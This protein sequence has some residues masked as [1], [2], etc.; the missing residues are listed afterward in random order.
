MANDDWINKTNEINPV[1]IKASGVKSINLRDDEVVSGILFDD[2]AAE[3][4]T[5]LTDKGTGKRTRMTELE[6]TSRAK[7]GV[8]LMKV[9]QSNPSRIVKA[10][11]TNSKNLIGIVSDNYSREVK[12]NEI[13][14]MDRY[15]TGSAIVKTKI[16][17]IY[18]PVTLIK[19]SEVKKEE[20]SKPVTKEESKEKKEVSLKEIDDKFMTID[21]FLDNFD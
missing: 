21:D 6:K 7:R 2:K 13:P 16:D 4:I 12:I 3:F 10:Y 15:S 1:G 18:E 5:I 19:V 14:I 9:I 8:L 20:V 17:E 11:I